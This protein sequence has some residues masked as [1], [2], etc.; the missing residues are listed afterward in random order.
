[1][2]CTRSVYLS[3]WSIGIIIFYSICSQRKIVER[4]LISVDFLPLFFCIQGYAA[5]AIC[6]LE[7]AERIMLGMFHHLGTS[8]EKADFNKVL[9]NV[10]CTLGRA[11]TKIRKYP[12][13]Q[14]SLCIYIYSS[15]VCVTS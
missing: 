6:H 14:C 10:Y 8:Q 4:F 1:M 3:A 15:N 5:Q 9:V 11:L 12:F 2:I 7:T 13:N